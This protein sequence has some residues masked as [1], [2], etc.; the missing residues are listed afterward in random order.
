MSIRLRLTLF[1]TAILALTL[2]AFSSILYVSQTRATYASIKANLA[3]QVAGFVRATEHAPGPP[4]GQAETAPAPGSPPPDKPIVMDL[5]SSTLP[6]RWTQTRSITG[7]VMGQT[8]DLS[9]TT[10]PLSAQG[11]EAVQGGSSWYET[12][13]VDNEPLL[14]YSL[15]HTTQNGV[16]VIVQV[17]FPIAQPQQSLN[18][19]RLVLI[20]G[21]TLAILAAFALGWVLAGTALR[22]IQRITQTAQAIGAERNFGR[23][24]EHKGPADEVGQLAVTFNVMLAELESGYRQLEDALYSQRRFV[25]DASHELRTPLT[26][27]RGN[28]ELLRREPPIDASERAEIVA[29]TTEEVDRLIRLVNELLVLAR[30][31]A[32][33][34][35]RADSIPVQALIED[36]CRQARLLTPNTR[37]Q[38]EA[39]ADVLVQGDRDALKQV[40][41]ILVDNALVHTPAGTP[42]ALTASA[43]DAR[44]V[45]SVR[46]SGPGIAPEALPH[47]FERFYRGQASRTGRGAGLGL[48]IAKELVEAQD[49][50]ITV[51]SQLSQGSA[52]TITLPAA[53]PDQ[54]QL[55]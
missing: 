9:G 12:A 47:I 19:L 11:L 13:Q 32:G 18:A 21:N 55:P 44:V 26:T 51:E 28:I 16:T 40:L 39:P 48:A 14:I 10:L 52:F 31:D 38:C 41:L 50:T 15:P 25:A 43:T 24:V 49:G 42:V 37:I 54:P 27:V 4:P 34:T 23:R 1:Y 30:A 3:G 29:D 8:P 5:S 45:F 2:I 20:V 7:T 53:P 22:P 17:A 35:L 36:V 33:Q 46:D 6:G